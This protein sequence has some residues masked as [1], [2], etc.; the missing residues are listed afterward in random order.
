M[1]K[2][3]NL[4]NEVCDLPSPPEPPPKICPTC[5]IDPDYAEPVWWETTAA[6]LNLKICEYQVAITSK[7][8]WRNKSPAEIKYLAQKSVKAGIREII[9]E[10]SKI[11][12]TSDICAFPPVRSS[13]QCRLYLPPELILE[14]ERQEES[15]ST[16][17]VERDIEYNKNDPEFRFNLEALEIH[18]YVKD[19][20]YGDRAETFKIH[21]SIPAEY[22]DLLDDAPF[23]DEEQDEI[24]E[25]T[26]DRNVVVL[27]GRKFKNNILQLKAIFN[28]YSRYQS[29]YFTLQKVSLLQDLGEVTKKFYIAKYPPMLE[30]FKELLDDLLDNNNYKLRRFKSP[31]TVDKIRIKFDKRDPR[32]PYLIKSI[33]ARYAGCPYRK[34]QGLK[35]FKKAEVVKNQTLMHYIA[36]SKDMIDQIEFASEPPPWIDFVVERTYP[37]LTIDFGSADTANDDLDSCLDS[38]YLSELRDTILEESFSFLEALE[39]SFNIKGCQDIE[40]YKD[41]NSIEKQRKRNRREK[42]TKE[43]RKAKRANKKQ[44]KQSERDAKK[45]AREARQDLQDKIDALKTNVKQDAEDRIELPD[46]NVIDQ[47]SGY[48]INLYKVKNADQKDQ[49]EEALKAQKSSLLFAIRTAEDTLKQVSSGALGALQES[50]IE[51]YIEERQEQLDSVKAELRELRRLKRHEAFPIT[52]TLSLENMTKLWKEAQ[53]EDYA[54][55]PG[56]LRRL[57]KQ[58]GK[59]GREMRREKYGPLQRKKKGGKGI[60]KNLLTR[61]N[62]CTWEGVLF[63]AV[64][65]LLGGMSLQEAIPI[66]IRST[67]SKSS[68]FV[69]EK[70]VQGLPPDVQ[71]QVK[72]KVKAELQKI[73]NE[74]SAA[75]KEPWEAEREK[76]KEENLNDSTGSRDSELDQTEPE[77]REVD[78]SPTENAERRELRREKRK[79]ERDTEELREEKKKLLEEGANSFTSEPVLLID[80]GINKN[81]K[82]I[83]EIEKQMNDLSEQIAQEDSVESQALNNIAS[84]IFDAYVEA[85]IEYAGVDRLT[86]MIDKIPGANV[87]KRVFLQAACPTADPLSLGVSDLFGSLKIS[88]CKDGANGYM[89]PSA[90]NLPVFRG[91]GIEAALNVVWGEFR[92]KLSDLLGEIILALFIKILELLDD[93]QCKSVGALGALLANQLTGQ[94]GS[95]SGLL[96]AINDAF[97]NSDGNAK[98]TQDDLLD[99]AGIPDYAKSDLANGISRAMSPSEIKQA[100]LDCEQVSDKVWTAIYGVIQVSFPDLLEIINGPNDVQEIFC[101]MGSYLSP[102]QRQGLQSRMDPT[103]DLENLPIDNSICLTNSQRDRVGSTKNRFL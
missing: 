13:Q 28:L 66:I 11:E 43:Q 32:K 98:D 26:Q 59:S 72:Q 16:P 48:Q 93:L 83:K 89:L 31:R 101:I 58:F 91:I 85:L 55:Q 80:A 60:A 5:A 96:D 20:Y 2:F 49:A 65:C 61:L 52:E 10:F 19:I 94:Q 67:L 81:V 79:L 82:R 95:R 9:R 25:E 24:E 46:L 29:A 12:L 30:Q 37:P 14:L 34:L 51:D 33:E 36:N 17:Q 44:E 71:Q 35:Q 87:F 78:D 68:P 23:G 40:N 15:F 6:Y 70:V 41:E 39:F 99:R 53:G 64:E 3:K 75:F 103:S 57:S 63:E 73:S 1:S 18:A 27:D 56:L 102:D 100:L 77:F 8:D 21:V 76:A 84:I 54:K 4:Q 69:L 86:E 88:V 38:E 47:L 22:I 50:R 7:E 97:C 92:E 62:P 74:A 42:L 45:K 90:P